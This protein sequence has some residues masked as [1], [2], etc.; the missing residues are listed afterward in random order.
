MEPYYFEAGIEIRGAAVST[1]EELAHPL[2]RLAG[3][4]K[5]GL[6]RVLNPTEWE[7]L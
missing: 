7:R 5:L 1:P 2:V 6:F 3:W 4:V